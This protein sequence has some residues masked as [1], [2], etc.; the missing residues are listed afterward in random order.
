M[1]A[2]SRNLLY[3]LSLLPGVLVIYGNL[4][5]GAFNASLN[6]LFS[7]GVLGAV[8]WVSK[9]FLSEAH[10]GEADVIPN[11]ILIL[12][13]PIQV[14]CILSFVYAV[15]ENIHSDYTLFLSALSMGVYTGSGA[16]VVAHEC[17]HRKS[18][19]WQWMGRFLLFTAGN[20]YFFVEHLRVHHKWVGTDRDAATAKRGQNVYQFFATSGIGQLTGAWK[21]ENERLRKEG[22]SVFSLRH[23][24]IR[25][26]V[27]HALFDT[28]LV[29]LAGPLALAAWFVQCILA[30]F[31]LEYVNYIE[32]YGLSR[33]EKERVTEIHSWQSDRFVSRF[34][35]VDLSRHADHHFY[36]SKPYH[37]LKS[38]A[39]SP[40]LPAGY[41]SL[42]VPALIPPLWR[43][44]IH[45][46]L[47]AAGNNEA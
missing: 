18:P 19:V 30:N 33:G 1:T 38:Y 9:P 8:D 24:V 12:H 17:I 40:V 37:T 47:D 46:I 44:L 11:A 29:W 28:V 6:L 10:S 42:I 23:Y 41:P 22:K 26:L 3:T 5:E 2:S 27:L 32:H 4:H 21:L 34:L 39:Q 13:I 35:L 31:L 15:R 43:W 16:I 45:P 36:A 25:Q 20:F 14:M 7:L